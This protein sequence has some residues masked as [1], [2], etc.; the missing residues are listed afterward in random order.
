MALE[1]PMTELMSVNYLEHCDGLF[2]F[3]TIFTLSIIL[4]N[5]PKMNFIFPPPASTTLVPT[6]P[7]HH[8]T[9]T[10]EL[11]LHSRYIA[12]RKFALAKAPLCRHSKYT[13]KKDQRPA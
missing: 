10:T 8:K 13:F 7:Q 5:L 9:T 12:R 2:T 6:I 4:L 11:Y 3:R 1:P